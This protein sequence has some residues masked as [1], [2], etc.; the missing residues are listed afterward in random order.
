MTNEE[1][2]WRPRTDTM[3]KEEAEKQRRTNLKIYERRC[4]EGR[5]L[6]TGRLLTPEELE[7]D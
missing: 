6:F 2:T 1:L 7:N 5:D 4:A 3:T